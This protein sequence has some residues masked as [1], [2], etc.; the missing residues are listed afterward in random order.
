MPDTAVSRACTTRRM[1]GAAEIS[2]RA[3]R[4]RSARRIDVGPLAGTSAT[5][6]ITRSNQFHGSLKK[7]RWSRSRW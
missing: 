4:I 2:R 1:L 7:S 6:T 5:S 3:R